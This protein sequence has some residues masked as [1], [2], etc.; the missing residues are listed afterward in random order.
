MKRFY[1]I[2]VKRRLINLGNVLFTRYFEGY[3]FVITTRLTAHFMGFPVAT[4]VV[5]GWC[6]I[7]LIQLTAAVMKMYGYPKG[8]SPVQHQNQY[9]SYLFHYVYKANSRILLNAMTKIRYS[10]TIV[11]CF[12]V[13]FATAL[14]ALDANYS[15]PQIRN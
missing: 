10:Y 1:S 13:H 14:K 3:L 4:M 6:K 5:F 15:L 7:N 12:L 11:N 9:D 8:G 2:E